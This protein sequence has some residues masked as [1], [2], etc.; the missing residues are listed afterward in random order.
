MQKLKKVNNKNNKIE[1]GIARYCNTFII[2]DN[3]NRTSDFRGLCA[4]MLVKIP[5]TIGHCFYA[6]ILNLDKV[7]N[8]VLNDNNSRLTYLLLREQ[9]VL[10][11]VMFLFLTKLFSNVFF[12]FRC[13]FGD[14]SIASFYLVHPPIRL[15]EAVQTINGKEK[16]KVVYIGD[17]NERNPDMSFAVCWKYVKCFLKK[18]CCTRSKKPLFLLQV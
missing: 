1:E 12:F 16:G 8:K 10:E 9:I 17:P 6:R 18:G 3:D 15:D 14:S 13:S 2:P 11:E 5:E 7:N 4:N